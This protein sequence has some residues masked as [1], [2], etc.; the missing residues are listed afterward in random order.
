MDD[1]HRS[2]VDGR[3][4]GRDRSQ[5]GPAVGTGDVAAAVRA[6]DGQPD[7]FGFVAENVVR[8]AGQRA[9]VDGQVRMGGQQG[10]GDV[11]QQ[12]AL[13]GSGARSSSARVDAGRWIGT[14]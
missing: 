7:A 4:R 14:A 8:G 9:Q 5:G 11:L 1:R 12:G 2:R 13:S 6:D 3:Q 10:E